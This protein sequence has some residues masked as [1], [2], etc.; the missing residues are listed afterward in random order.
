MVLADDADE[1]ASTISI[2]AVTAVARGLPVGS[3]E[4][5]LTASGVV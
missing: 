2:R 4:R 5:P 1:A 3:L